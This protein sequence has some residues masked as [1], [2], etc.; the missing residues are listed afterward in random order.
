VWDKDYL[1]PKHQYYWNL[2]P[3]SRNNN[4]QTRSIGWRHKDICAL[5]SWFSLL[6]KQ[7][8]REDSPSHTH[9]DRCG[10]MNL[11]RTK[12]SPN[13]VLKCLL[14]SFARSDISL[15]PYIGIRCNFTRQM[16]HMELYFL[17]F[18]GQMEFRNIL[19]Q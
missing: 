16:R 1:K 5:I 4:L 17:K 7:T 14:T 9:K 15:K 6:E 19:F 8:R 2:R 18:S 12:S 11:I 10:N 3:L 13:L